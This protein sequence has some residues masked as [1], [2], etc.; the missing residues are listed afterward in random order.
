[1]GD[2]QNGRRGA[3]DKLGDLRFSCCVKVIGRLIEDDKVWVI[4]KRGA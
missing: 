4:K 2:D 1:M 3:G